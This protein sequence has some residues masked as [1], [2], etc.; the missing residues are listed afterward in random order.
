MLDLNNNKFTYREE[1]QQAKRGSMHNT[2]EKEFNKEHE[3]KITRANLKAADDLQNY[4]KAVQESRKHDYYKLK[5]NKR[6]GMFDV[7][8]RRNPMIFI[9]GCGIVGL[10]FNAFIITAVFFPEAFRTFFGF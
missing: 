2:Y 10:T 6:S 9:L 4:Y 8:E 1:K 7:V 5:Y 3:L